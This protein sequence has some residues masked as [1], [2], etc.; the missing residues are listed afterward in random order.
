VILYFYTPAFILRKNGHII[1]RFCGCFSGAIPFMFW[2]AATGDFG[3]EAG[4][5]FSI[6]WQ[7]IFWAIGSV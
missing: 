1:I 7:F 3:I 5:L 6:F 4:T 2:V